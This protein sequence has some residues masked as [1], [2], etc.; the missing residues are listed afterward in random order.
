MLNTLGRVSEM[1][2]YPVKSMAGESLT[3][4]HIEA[5]GMY[6]DRSHAFVDETEQGWDRFVTARDIPELLDYRA[7]LQGEGSNH[8]F[9]EAAV[10]DREG[11]SFSWNDRL[12]RE[13]QARSS[14]QISMLRYTPDS[15]ELLGVDTGSLLL[16][17]D[18]TLKQLEQAWGKP[19]DK[20]RFRANVVI[21]LAD[22]SLHEGKWIGRQLQIGDD[23]LLKVD[24]YCERCAMITIDPDTIAKDPSLLKTVVIEMHGFFGVYASVVKTGHIREGDAVYLM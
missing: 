24:E 20:R 5:Y 12:L 22:D 11:N 4:G 9:P 7:S 16:I 13:I 18:G 6:G 3:A 10:W 1:Y 14:R 21:A 23:V 17:T 8:E 2:R 19:L 15:K